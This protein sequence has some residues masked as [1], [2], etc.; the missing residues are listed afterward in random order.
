MSIADKLQR[1]LD[2]KEDIRVAI[3]GKGRDLTGKTFEDDW[4]NEIT[5]IETGGGGVTITG[6]QTLQGIAAE[7]V[8]E[9]DTIYTKSY[10]A[11]INV[12]LNEPDVQPT[13]SA[14]AVE[15][16]NDDVYAAVA[17]PTSPYVTI[18]KRNGDDFTKIDVPL[19]EVPTGQAE[20][21]A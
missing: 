7:P 1:V 19:T 9:G 14:Y 10:N 20:D 4:A 5:A 3:E 18:Y 17:H 15:F 2:T 11:H 6:A 16:T 13:N 21:L 8:V 12:L